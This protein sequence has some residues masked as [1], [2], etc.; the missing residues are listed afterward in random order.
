MSTQ[1]PEVLRLV[2][3]TR[4]FGSLTAVDGLNLRVQP[5]E[6]VGFLGPNGAGKTT[7]LG[8]IAGLLR[9]DSGQIELLS[10]DG[11]LPGSRRGVGFL[12]GPPAL[13]PNLTGLEHLT[14]TRRIVLASGWSPAG[15][16]CD[17]SQLL[18]IVGLEPRDG[19]RLVR[20]YSQG[21]RQRLGL[22]MALTGN[23][24]L[25]VLD[26]PTNGLDPLGGPD[27]WEVLRQAAGRGVGVLVSTHL[28]L[29]VE[30]YCDRAPM[31][32][33]GRLVHADVLSL[34]RDQSTARVVKL[35]FLSSEDGARVVAGLKEWEAIVDSSEIR[36]NDSDMSVL[37]LTL[38]ALEVP[39]LLEHLAAR[40]L[41]L[42][43]RIEP[44][45]STLNDLFV[46][47]AGEGS[48]P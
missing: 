17:P 24:A 19:K 4:S 48:R 29:E 35:E 31:L 36:D 26:E 30:R 42:P 33:S 44:E 21:M 25:L 45:E 41:P 1:N 14:H 40:G 2:D 20:E 6:I 3:L 18:K 5:G 47:L 43:C 28:L 12:V 23:P 38:P 39:R 16:D 27:I 46:R 37:R 32:M 7:T 8:M 9:P 15:D 22:A 10:R 13:W 11:T 34:L